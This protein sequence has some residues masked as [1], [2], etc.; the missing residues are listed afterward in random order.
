MQMRSM[1]FQAQGPQKPE[2]LSEVPHYLKEVFTGFFSRLLYIYGLVWQTSPWMLFVM[3]FMSVFN[4]VMP[5]IGA[6]ISRDLINALI[7]ISGGDFQQILRLLVLEFAFT[8]I[9]RLVGSVYNT[10]TKTFGEMV[11][12]NI[13][14]RIMIKANDLDLQS[15]DRPEFFERLENAEHE[16]GHRPVQIASATFTAMSTLISMISFVTVLWKVSPAAPLVIVA[17]S[18]PSALVNYIYK[19]KSADYM[20][21]RSVDRRR[22]EYYARLVIDKD[23]AKEIRLFRLGKTFVKRYDEVFEKYFGGLKKLVYREGLW[24]GVSS[25]FMNVVTCGIYIWVAYKVFNGELTVGDYTLYTG[26]LNQISSGVTSLISTTATIYEGTLFID[27]MIA[28]MKEKKTIVPSI[29]P[30]AEVKRQHHVIEFQHVYFRYPEMDH[31]VLKDINL[32]FESGESIVLVGLNGAGKTTLLKLM[33]R[34]CYE[35][36]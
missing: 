15:F 7:N 30:A 21:M 31:D 35:V 2:R 19:G 16:A 14:K 24:N 1:R 3:L 32:R 5:L 28:F 20:R 27:N 33:T 9:Y 8:F 25:A 18:I 36:G 11:T 23:M 13:Q 17:A 12:H 10:L 22:M 6:M 34:L 29:E 4:G 26:A